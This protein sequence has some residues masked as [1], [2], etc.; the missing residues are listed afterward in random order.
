MCVNYRPPEIQFFDSMHVPRAIDLTWP[1]ETW[2]DYDAPII[3]RSESGREMI[4]ASYGMVPKRHLPPGGP[5]ITTLNARAETIGE[6]RAYAKPWR[7]AQLCLV[8]ME[9]FY[10]PR[11]EDGKHERWRIGMADDSTFAVAGLWRSWDEPDGSTSHSFTQI[12]INADAHP[13]MKSFHKPEDEKRSLVI[14]PESEYDDWLES[15]DPE[16]ARSYLQLYPAELMAARPAPRPPKTR[17]T[18]QPSLI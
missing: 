8:P 6:R 17:Q 11:W 18:D 14:V 4:L 15:T 12:T 1:E 13:L 9:A 2:Q 7:Q 16:R 5:R 10:E 3:R